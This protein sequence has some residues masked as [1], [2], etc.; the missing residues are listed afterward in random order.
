[1]DEEFFSVWLDE[2]NSGFPEYAFFDWPR[3]EFN[4][5]QNYF[6]LFISY[7]HNEPNKKYIEHCSISKPEPPA[8]DKTKDRHFLVSILR[9]PG[10][11]KET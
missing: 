9:N 7:S 3:E 11:M 4:D 2:N 6:N 1:M 8:F 10:C 5:R